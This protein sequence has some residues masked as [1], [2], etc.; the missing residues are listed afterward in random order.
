ML[1][2]RRE[3]LTR[4]CIVTHARARGGFDIAFSSM[5]L[6][7]GHSS[8]PVV[9][10]GL[11]QVKPSVWRRKQGR[12]M[13]GHS[14]SERQDALVA[15]RLS[16]YE[17]DGSLRGKAIVDLQ[18]SVYLLGHLMSIPGFDINDETKRRLIRNGLKRMRTAL[19]TGAT[20]CRRTFIQKE[21]H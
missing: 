18:M 10:Y 5:V 21:N 13:P 12:V 9:W 17:P 1:K 6:L 20:P 8:M 15:E 7:L 16:L 11:E 14:E 3:W 4:A 2:N 19:M